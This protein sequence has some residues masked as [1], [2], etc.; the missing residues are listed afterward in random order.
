MARPSHGVDKALLAAGEEEIKAKGVRGLSVRGVSARA[1]VSLRMM[2]YYFG[3]KDNF[4]RKILNKCYDEYY[5][6]LKSHA[7]SSGSPLTRLRRVV[8]ISSH[9]MLKNRAMGR[10]LWIDANAGEKVVLEIMSMHTP[11]H[12]GLILRLVREAQAEGELR[13]DLDA[14]QI[15]LATMP[16]VFMGACLSDTCD[17][18]PIARSIFSEDVAIPAYD[19]AQIMANYDCIIYGF[20]TEQGRKLSAEAYGESK[21]ESLQP[22]LRLSSPV[23]PRGANCPQPQKSQQTHRGKSL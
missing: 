5:T 2:N 23:A 4:V 6:E 12:S 8:E 14:R 10:N 3:S 19:E 18:S 17:C 9:F 20:M 11:M 22:A 1:G 7:Q 15:Y 16:G 21:P 13:Q